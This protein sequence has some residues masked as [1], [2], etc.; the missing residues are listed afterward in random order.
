MDGWLQAP[1]SISSGWVPQSSLF[2]VNP[3][4]S[5]FQLQ[6]Y[7]TSLENSI[8]GRQKA[9]KAPKMP[10][11]AK[12]KSRKGRVFFGEAEKKLSSAPRG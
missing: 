4:P 11:S 10:D 6:S 2:S 9:Q 1:G 7:S 5:G 3:N 8:L 12:A